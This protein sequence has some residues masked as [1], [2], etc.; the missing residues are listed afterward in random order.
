M[1]VAAVMGVVVV[2]TGAAL[3]IA[4]YEVAQHRVRAAADLAAV[5]AAVAFGQGQDACAQA[6][7]TAR[8]NG[9]SLLSCSTAGDLVAYVV[10]VQV[11]LPVRTTVRGLPSRVVGTS[12]AGST[13]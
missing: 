13:P 2:L 1:L 8:A 10:T 5:S 11:A 7:R 6:R 3:L 12:H 9:A 4:G